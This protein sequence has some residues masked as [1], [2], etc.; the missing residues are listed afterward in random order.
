MYSCF[1]AM[2]SI[3]HGPACYRRSTTQ[4]RILTCIKCNKQHHSRCFK[5]S[6]NKRECKAS[7]WLCNACSLPIKVKCNGCKKIIAESNLRHQCKNCSAFFHKKCLNE[8]C[9]T[10]LNT[11]M[12]FSTIDNTTFKLNLGGMVSTSEKLKKHA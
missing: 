10:C 9:F 8:I 2:N 11:D 1:K 12:P 5:R 7:E 4:L 3:I 6:K